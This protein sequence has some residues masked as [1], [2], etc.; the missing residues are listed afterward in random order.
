MAAK[1]SG[2]QTVPN[3]TSPV[4]STQT[5]TVTH[6]DAP[7][8]AHDP[9]TELFLLAVTNMVGEKTFYESGKVR[10][11]RFVDLLHTVTKTDPD[12]MYRFI[13]WLRNTA[14]M[15][16][17][18]VVAA[19]EY[20]AAGGP[21]GRQL[22]AA[23]LSRPDEPAELIA[24][25]MI[26]HG[27]KLP[28]PLKRGIADAI[29]R[30]YNEHSA[31]KYD[32]QSRAWRMGDV[33]ELTHPIPKAT[34][35]SA[36]FKY[37]LDRRHH[38]ADVKIDGRTLKTIKARQTLEAIPERDRRTLWEAGDEL[39]DAAAITWEWLSGWLPGGMDAAAW[40][41]VIPHMGYM[42]LLRN[43]RNF[44]EA[45]IDDKTADYVRAVIADPDR[46]AKSRQFPYRFYSAY[47]AA[48]SL[49]WARTLETALDLSCANIPEL[50]GNTLVM[51]DTSGSMQATVSDR[52]MIC[53]YEVAAIFGAAIAAKAE[54]V[55]FV[56][57]ADRYTVLPFRKGQS[58]LRTADTIHGHIGRDGHGTVLGQALA[59]TFRP[60]Y[61]DR[62][63]IFSDLQL[64]D[65][66][67]KIGSRGTYGFGH[68]DTQTVVPIDLANATVYL[69]NTGGYHST[70]FQVGSKGIYG[71][72]GFTDATFRMMAILEQ[73]KD[74]SW[75]F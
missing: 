68:V 60:G 20:I 8:Y 65:G 74:A 14:Q 57:W 4:R 17:A 2:K 73:F 50:A 34:W 46:V 36:L 69:F 28:Q 55:T 15:R 47:K 38:P 43:L 30:L 42:A 56:S 75:P 13:P 23:T 70:P 48:P 29:G 72:G 45:G 39:F 9:K 58:I 49:N 71:L 51:V 53:H 6:E 5:T 35:Q 61:H 44:D 66:N 22:V 37:L 18:S 40:Q 31:L 1:F 3:R 10:D 41:G 27:R 25:W 21:N 33:I 64:M 63:V 67:G 26:E 11:S 7:A 54:E 24:Y 12:W 19:A 52:S 59:G 62:V 16:S 32:G